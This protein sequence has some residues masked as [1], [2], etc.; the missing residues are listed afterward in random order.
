MERPTVARIH[1]ENLTQDLLGLMHLAC[2]LVPQSKNKEF[3][4]LCQTHLD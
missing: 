1:G 2:F 4:D 3:D